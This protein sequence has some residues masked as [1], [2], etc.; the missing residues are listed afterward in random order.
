V[1]RSCQNKKYYVESRAEKILHNIKGKKAN[2]IGYV[3]RRNCFL[4]HV[5]E[6]KM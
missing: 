2:W 6:G 4:R 5:T 1:D 3:L